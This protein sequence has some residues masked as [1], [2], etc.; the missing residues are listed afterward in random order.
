MLVS[1]EEPSVLKFCDRAANGSS[2]VLDVEEWLLEDWLED[3]RCE[4]CKSI[5]IGERPGVK[6]ISPAPTGSKPR[7]WME[8]FQLGNSQ[9]VWK[10]IKQE[11][12]GW[13]PDQGKGSA[14][15]VGR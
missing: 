2:Y 7:N 6:K 13:A 11:T 8:G 3:G 9:P 15:G 10:V 12:G 1:R 14:G 5:F 4:I